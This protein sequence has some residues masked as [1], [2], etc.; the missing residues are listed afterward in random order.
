VIDVVVACGQDENGIRVFRPQLLDAKP[1]LPGNPRSKMSRREIRAL[2]ARRDSIT[3]AFD[4]NG[5]PVFSRYHA[6]LAKRTSS[7]TNSIDARGQC[8]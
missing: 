3:A 8:S 7:S 5:K 6:P 2:T 1:I 4:G